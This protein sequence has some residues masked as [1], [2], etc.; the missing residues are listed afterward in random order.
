MANHKQQCE[1]FCKEVTGEGSLGKTNY[2]PGP[3]YVLNLFL[4]KYQL[5]LL[6]AYWNWLMQLQKFLGNR[7]VTQTE[8][9]LVFFL[10]YNL[11]PENSYCVMFFPPFI[12][13]NIWG[14]GIYEYLSFHFKACFF[15]FF[16]IIFRYGFLFCYVW[17]NAYFDLLSKRLGVP[18]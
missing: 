10:F 9:L 8:I 17:L 7:V 14:G 4:S 1:R 15:G 16:Y 11:V 5:W 18:T 6:L 3:M 13:I 2:C 12:L